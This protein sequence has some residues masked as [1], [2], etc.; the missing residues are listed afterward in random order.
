[1]GVGG[2]L[3]GAALEVVR[4]LAVVMWEGVGAGA[5]VGAGVGPSV[6][7]GVG[8]G[9]G[10]GAGAVS[11][12][13]GVPGGGGHVVA[14]VRGDRVEQVHP[15]PILQPS[16]SLISQQ[17]P[18]LAKYTGE[19]T[20]G[21]ETVGEWLEQF[22]LVATACHWDEPTKLVNLVTRLKGQAFAFYH[23]CDG[24][25]RNQPW[26]KLLGIFGEK[27]VGFS[28]Q[29]IWATLLEFLVITGEILARTGLYCS[30]GTYQ[31]STSC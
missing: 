4:G 15:R 25:K 14:G 21:A 24:K 22:E 1:M 28:N 29:E 7:V 31:V 16:V 5:G 8:V 30:L 20:E 6:G 27:W 17:L 26:H 10:A 13:E 18:P 23:S 12:G 11:G 19:P 2:V 9:V 3:R